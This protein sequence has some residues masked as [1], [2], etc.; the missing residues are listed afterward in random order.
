MAALGQSHQAGVGQERTLTDGSTYPVTAHRHIANDFVISGQILS[1]FLH[2]PY[3]VSDSRLNWLKGL[4]MDKERYET[5]RE[6]LNHMCRLTIV[7]QDKLK[8]GEWA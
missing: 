3:R 7:R 4:R 2:C 1:L 6:I 5:S 8:E